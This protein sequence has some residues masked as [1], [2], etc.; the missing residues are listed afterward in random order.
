MSSE[1]FDGMD[2]LTMMELGL[3]A[4]HEGPDYFVSL[5]NRTEEDD[6]LEKQVKKHGMDYGLDDLSTDEPNT[7]VNTDGRFTR[8]QRL[9]Y[10]AEDVRKPED[11]AIDSRDGETTPQELEIE[12][13]RRMYS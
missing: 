8:A 9:V 10:E 4:Q 1:F 6:K 5:L 12:E 2:R 3:T 11:L 13:V 7:N